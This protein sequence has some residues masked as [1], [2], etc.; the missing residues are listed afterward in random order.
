M[1]KGDDT[2]VAAAGRGPIVN[3]LASPALATAGTGDV[4]SGMIAAL[5]ARGLEPR[6]GRRGRRPRPH[7]RR[8]YCGAAR[9]RGGVGDR[10]RRD[11]GDPGRPAT[12][13]DRVR[14]RA[15]IDTGAVER[16][17]RRLA[18]ELGDGT[19]LCAVV[20]ADA[21]GHGVIPCGRAALAGGAG[22]LAV[23]A[24]SEAV[25]L[26]RS[27]ARSRRSSCSAP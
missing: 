21:Y 6:D 26:R 23:A 3:G 18:A 12:R 1:L 27:S 24:A 2:I 10:D 7:P 13:T 4:L 15:L 5:I 19:V 22:W 9:R 20:K 8:A 16:N 17:C 25:D 11:R 14:A